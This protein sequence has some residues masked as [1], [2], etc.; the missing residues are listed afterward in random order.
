[1]IHQ[2]G[3]NRRYATTVQA[4]DPA[5][6]GDRVNATR[7]D[8]GMGAWVY[9]QNFFAGVSAMQ[10]LNNQNSFTATNTFD[11]PGLAVPHFYLTGGYRFDVNR[12]LTLVPSFMLKVAKPSVAPDVNLKAILAERV[13]GGVS[14]RH[15]DA[16][17]VLAGINISP[18]LD[19]GYSYDA[20]TS[21]LRHAS[22]GSHEVV[23]GLKLQNRGKAICPQW[24]W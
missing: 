6:M 13:W 14:Y 5:L 19:L 24:M 12:D 7:M 23:V 11:Q 4:N 3:I 17:S 21:E 9:S 18:M 22:S 1:G 16:V 10:L 8:L 20:I 2:F 15:Q